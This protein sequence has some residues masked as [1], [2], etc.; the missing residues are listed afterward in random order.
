MS[1]LLLHSDDVPQT[2]RQALA[3]AMRGPAE[4]RYENLRE[5][6]V[7]LHR[8]VGLDCKDARELVGLGDTLET[9][10]ACSC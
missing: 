3:S 1:A 2:A 5:A 8:E 7:I 10:P 9:W 4:Q 6:A